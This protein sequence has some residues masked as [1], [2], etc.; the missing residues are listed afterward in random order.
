[1]V[2]VDAH[3]PVV[4]VN[5]YVVVAVLLIAGAHVPFIALLEVVGKLKEP[6]AQIAAT[7][8][9]VGVVGE[10]SNKEAVLDAVPVAVV[11]ETIPETPTPT[12]AVI[13]VA[14]TTVND[15]AAVPP[16]E[17]AVAP[18]KLVPVIVIVPPE[19]EQIELG[20]N[21]ETVGAGLTA[22]AFVTPKKGE[23]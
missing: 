22:T 19:V 16:I 4:G 8:V 6:P 14:F 15:V 17:T 21:D 23:L 5:A 11:T 18:V 1:M 10:V 9:N 2:V 7:C 13:C 20:V 3:W 12:T